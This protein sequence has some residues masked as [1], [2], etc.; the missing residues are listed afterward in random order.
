VLHLT[1][2]RIGMAFGDVGTLQFRIRSDAL[3]AFDAD[4]VTARPS[5]G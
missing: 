1:P 5:S 4:A 2:D 3:G